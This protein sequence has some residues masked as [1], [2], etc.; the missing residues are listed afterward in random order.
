MWTL[1]S[2]DGSGLAKVTIRIGRGGPKTLGRAPRA[3]FVVDV[4]LVSRL[5]CRL[6]AADSGTLQVED[7]D[8]TNGTFVNERR[9]TRSVLVPGDRLRIGR[10]ELVVEP[11]NRE[12]SGA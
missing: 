5:H 1:R 11:E 2:A 3:D 7:L 8:S 6:S 4:P 12:T 9:V 10:L